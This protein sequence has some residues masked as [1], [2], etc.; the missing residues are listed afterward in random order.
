LLLTRLLT[1]GGNLVAIPPRCRFYVVGVQVSAPYNFTTTDLGAAAAAGAGGGGGGSG[2]ALVAVQFSYDT[3]FR[4]AAAAAF[5]PFGD[6]APITFGGGSGGSGGDDDT[7]TCGTSAS[8]S[9]SSRAGGMRYPVQ[10][11]TIAPVLPNGMVLLGET[12]KLV[13]VSAQ[14]VASV[15]IIAATA[16]TATADDDGDN[17]DEFVAAGASVVV[18]VRGR[19]GEQV[20]FGALGADGQLVHATTTVGADGTG[21]VTL[22]AR[23]AAA[24][25]AA[26]GSRD[27]K[28]RRR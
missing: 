11:Y 6:A 9:S 10:Y 5:R 1:D 26:T 23:T 17:D 25:T 27:E 20:E 18:G 16:T 14:R 7:V 3:V 15:A 19:P 21:S 13:P 8:S 4:P 12:G 22:A 2:S 24:T 28:R